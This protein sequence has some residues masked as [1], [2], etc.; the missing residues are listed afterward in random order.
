MDQRTR[1][2]SNRPM[3]AGDFYRSMGIWEAAWNVALDR[4][5]SEL[6]APAARRIQDIV[7][8]RTVARWPTRDSAA[9]EE[10]G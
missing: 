9:P 6:I 5:H 4:L 1:A 3:T 8:G 10:D 2:D 7:R